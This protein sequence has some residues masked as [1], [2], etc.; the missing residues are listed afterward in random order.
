MN[1][2]GL[3]KYEDNKTS[4]ERLEPP[5]TVATL[6]AVSMMFLRCCA[7]DTWQTAPTTVIPLALSPS[8]AS[9]T[10]FCMQRPPTDA[11]KPAV[12]KSSR[13]IRSQER[14]ASRKGDQ[15]NEKIVAVS[16]G[17]GPA[18]GRRRRRRRPPGRGARR[19]LGRSPAWTPSRRPPS[20]PDAGI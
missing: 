6:T 2:F 17:S 4:P 5:S 9:S 11:Q 16:A 8:T 15:R 20:P 14:I 1:Y 13:E 10:F 19:W 7:S 3:S 18:C 12:R